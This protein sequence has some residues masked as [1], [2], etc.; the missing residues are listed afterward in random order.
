MKEQVPGNRSEHKPEISD[1]RLVEITKC[2][3]E[4]MDK[5]DI[6][7]GSF[8]LANL[9][10]LCDWRGNERKEW[11]A[12]ILNIE[13]ERDLRE[14]YPDIEWWQIRKLQSMLN[15]EREMDD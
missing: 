1:E 14:R 15:R 9:T 3:F 11:A 10:Q 4:E 2:L 8:S 7:A 13:D 6:G 5:T 12:I